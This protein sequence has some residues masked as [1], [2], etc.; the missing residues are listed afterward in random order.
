MSLS[1]KEKLEF[2]KRVIKEPYEKKD[3]IWYEAEFK[4]LIELYNFLK[5]NPKR[6]ENIF[7]ELTS[8]ASLDSNNIFYEMEYD[9]AIECL[10]GSY[11]RNIDKLL[12]LKKNLSST[13]YFP[14]MRRNVVKSFTGSRICTNSFITNNP[15][16]YYKLERALEKK[17][18]TIHV[19]LGYS[20][21]TPTNAVLNR[22]ALIYN[23]VNMLEENNYSVELDTFFLLKVENQ[24]IAYIKVRIKNVNEK[25]SLKTGVFPLTSKDFQRRIIFRVIESLNVQNR[26]WGTLYG[27]PVKD[28]EASSLLKIK[29]KDIYIASPLDIGIKGEDL[30]EDIENFLDYVKIKQYVNVRTR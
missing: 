1:E 23:L 18:I 12:E 10:L 29:D 8:I 4:S 6:N 7:R 17:F 19:N 5:T 24:E 11:D 26:K 2:Y 20:N 16:R 15:K 25:F 14:S 9:E 28:I 27:S 21:I 13:I 30:R 22:G 3:Y